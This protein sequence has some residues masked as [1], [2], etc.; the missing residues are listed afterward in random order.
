MLKV[1][2]EAARIPAAPCL[3]WHS[4][5]RPVFGGLSKAHHG[6]EAGSVGMLWGCQGAVEGV[7]SNPERH[8]G[9][10]KEDIFIFVTPLMQ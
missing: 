7:T 2:Q 3:A 1:G 8:I 5:R 6:E 9:H 10:N 4:I